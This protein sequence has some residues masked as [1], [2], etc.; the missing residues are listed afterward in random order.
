MKIPGL[1]ST[2]FALILV[3]ISSPLLADIKSDILD[4]L[5]DQ[6]GRDY[7]VRYLAGETVVRARPDANSEP[8]TTLKRG[9]QVDVV[10]REG[11]W[12]KI[13]PFSDENISGFVP[14]SSLS[15]SS[16]KETASSESDSIEIDLSGVSAKSPREIALGQL[17][18]VER[19]DLQKTRIEE[20]RVRREQERYRREDEREAREKREEAAK[21]RQYDREWEALVAESEAGDVELERQW[22]SLTELPGSITR[23]DSP[24]QIEKERR[25]ALQMKKRQFRRDQNEGQTNAGYSSDSLSDRARD[26]SSDSSNGHGSRSQR[27]DL[28]NS[29]A[30]RTSQH[31]SN[32]DDM[33][34]VQQKP[35]RRQRV[36]EPSPQVVTGKN[37]TAFH[38]R[39]KAIAYARMNG[40]SKIADQCRDKGARY[41]LTRFSEVEK[42]NSA[43]RTTFANPNCK[44]LKNGSWDCTAEVR[45]H[46]Y[47]MQ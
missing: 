11:R 16:G 45:G 7:D 5:D 33:S 1:L 40:N 12:A 47:R 32:N 13:M 29:S 22:E 28:S 10:S 9:N 27:S 25:R 39:D 37:L 4:S 31:D 26:T 14:L 36:F 41:D 18:R 42:G 23:L 43:V 6:S 20:D 30:S 3:H 8:I 35:K 15:H 46:C 44:Q 21:Q 38:D 24:Y 34:S 17:R 2:V 19:E